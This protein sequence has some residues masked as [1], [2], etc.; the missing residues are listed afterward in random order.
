LLEDCLA[1]EKPMRKLLAL[2][3]TAGGLVLL[4]PLW[5]EPS[6]ARITRIEIVKVEPAFSGRSFGDVGSYERVIGRA[7]GEVDPKHAA[8]GIIQDLELAP[9]TAKGG[10]EY[11]TDID[12]L[13]PSDRSKG[14]GILF[15]NVVNRGNKGGLTAFN[16]DVPA[17][18]PQNLADNNALKVAGDGF[19]MEQGYTMVWFG[20]QGDVL[21]GNDRMTFSVPVAKNRDGSA[22]TGV[23]RSE[24]IVRSPAKTL[25][26]STGWFTLQNHASYASASVDNQTALA[27]GFLPTLSVRSKEQD[28]RVPI[29]NT[30]W[31]FASCSDAGPPL[32]GDRQIC[33]PAG[34]QPGRIY[35]L[36]YRA[37]DP[38]VLGLGFAAMR[39]LAAFLKHE[40]KD[41]TGAANPVYRAGTKALVMGT[42]QSGRFI[43]SFIQL[44]FNAD[45]EGRIA[46]EGA[47]PHIG[48]GLISLNIRFAQP[49]HAWGDQVDHLYPGYDFPFS[50]ARQT[51]P[52]TNRTQGVLDRCLASGTCPKIFHVATALEIWE[53]RQ[54]LGLTDPLGKRDVADPP[55]V[56][57]FIMAGTQH[58]PAPLPLPSAEPFGVC[59]QQPN[60]NPQVWTMRALLSALFGW[61]RDDKEPPPSAVPTIAGETLAPPSEVRFPTIPANAYGNVRRPAV[62]FL[63][64]HNPLHVLDFG[65]QYTA[66]DT[67]GVI[68]I[69]PPKRGEAPYGVLVHQV[70]DDG[71][72]LGGVRGLHLEVPIGTYTGWNLG[73]A[74]RFEDGFC[75]LTGSFIPFAQTKQ[76]RLETGDRRLSLE[77]R[78]PSTDSY[79][80]SVRKA[81]A[82]LVSARLLLPLDAQRLVG[83]AE[84]DGVRRAP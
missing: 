77:E 22:I 76:E 83:E 40:A 25:N 6:Q 84:S 4:A 16:A 65:A 43:R 31:S 14:N 15:F 8:N 66:A 36:I 82:K 72:D 12:I 51:D 62:R 27:D 28:P 32:A 69:E 74:E 60:P 70:D 18:L 21:A 26:L 49:G 3:A 55:N 64:V 35:E 20:W 45:E 34:F 57:T 80:A 37:K 58:V 46:F 73:R 79:V 38:L 44:G 63:A 61:V 30:E 71:N 1:R 50:Y 48:G 39:D 81:A 11:T 54:S 67:S 52:L 29:A 75:S 13:R 47:Y 41:E 59:Q 10:V 78:Y 24:L 23:V 17:G 68:S 53:G 42:S 7:Y 19:M 56:R 33:L 5:A 9:T 2:S